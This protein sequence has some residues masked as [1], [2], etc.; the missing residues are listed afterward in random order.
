MRDRVGFTLLEL[1]MVVVIIG[2]LASIAGPMYFKTVER[3]RISEAKRML[4]MIRMAQ[5][6]YYAEHGQFTNNMNEL[7]I[8]TADG[9]YFNL[10]TDVPTAGSATPGASNKTI[11]KV[12]RKADVQNPYGKAYTLEIRPNGEVCHSD[13]GAWPDELGELIPKC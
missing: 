13:D 6:R 5:M 11:G 8:D 9:K 3:S 2:I 4:G 1:I 12:Q 7:D 10:I